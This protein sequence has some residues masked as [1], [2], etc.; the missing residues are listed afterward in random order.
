MSKSI[1]TSFTGLVEKGSATCNPSGKCIAKAESSIAFCNKPN[2]CA[3]TT[4]TKDLYLNQNFGVI[5]KITTQGFETYFL[6][7]TGVTYTGA[8]LSRKVTNFT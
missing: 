1:N 2:D 6:R 8:G 4:T 7:C 5:Q 3:T